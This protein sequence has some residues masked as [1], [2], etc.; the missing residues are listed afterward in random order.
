MTAE[1]G[2]VG[3]GGNADGHPPDP[4]PASTILWHFKN[5][6][7]AAASKAGLDEFFGGAR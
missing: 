7:S 6:I 4:H 2:R 5:P 3:K 1:L